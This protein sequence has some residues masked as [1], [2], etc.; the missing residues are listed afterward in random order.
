MIHFE[1]FGNFSDEVFVRPSMSY[2][3]FP[4]DH[5]LS[6]ASLLFPA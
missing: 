1:S 5:E 2:H 4:A 6:I 3:L